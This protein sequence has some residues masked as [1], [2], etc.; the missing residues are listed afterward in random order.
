MTFTFQRL[1]YERIG[2]PFTGSRTIEV[3]Q[4][5][6][7]DVGSSP[8]GVGLPLQWLPWMLSLDCCRLVQEGWGGGLPLQW[9]PWMLSLDCCRLVQEGWGGVSPCSGYPGCYPWTAVGSSKRGGDGVSPCSSPLPS[10]G[11]Q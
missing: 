1:K 11:S 9:L 4:S 3:Y 2:K 8:R 10:R 7:P 5:N 6:M